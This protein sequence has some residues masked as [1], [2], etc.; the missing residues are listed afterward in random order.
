[1]RLYP[2]ESTQYYLI[3]WLYPIES[4]QRNLIMRLYPTE[5]TECNLI[6]R[7][8]P[9]E[10]TECNLI[11]RLYP[12]ES[13][14]RN[15]IM[16]LYPIESTECNLIMWLYPIEST[17]CNLIMR[18][19]PIE[20]TECNPI[21]R[22]YPTESTKCNLIMRL[23]PVSLVIRFCALWLSVEWETYA[24]HSV[25]ATTFCSSVCS[26]MRSTPPALPDRDVWLF[27]ASTLKM[28]PK[29]KLRIYRLFWVFFYESSQ[30]LNTFIYTNAQLERVLRFSIEEAWISK[31]LAGKA[32]T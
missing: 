28:S 30:Q 2:I 7:L 12:I 5:S 24:N 6:M 11:M 21:M 16:R 26:H 20:S 8:Y 19:Y 9:I 15:L 4:T 25:K 32:L 1:M 29:F 18:L 10:S 22:L 3:M 14:Q 31:L 27:S 13:T 23:Y 17:E